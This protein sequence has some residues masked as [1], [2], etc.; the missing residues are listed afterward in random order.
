M[1]RVLLVSLSHS[2]RSAAY[3]LLPFSFIALIAWSTAGSESGST[4]D[5]IRG[6]I[7]IW[8]GAHHIPFQ[9]SLPP[10]AIAGYLTYLPIGGLLLPLLVIRT[11]F[12]RALEKLKGDYHDLNAV[13]LNFSILYSL[14]VT[15][16]AFVSRS[17]PVAAQWYLAPLFAFV[18]ALI[19]T[20]TVGNRVVPSRSLRISL[21]VLSILLGV[22]LI[23]IS[24]LILLN[25]SQVRDI[26]TSLQPGIFGGLLLLFLNIL[27]LPNA[28]VAAASYFSGSG[29][30]VG[31]GSLIS[32]YWY[33]LDQ[34][35]ALPLLGILP[36]GREP[37]ALTGAI[38][39]IGLGVLMAYLTANFDL[40]AIAQSYLFAVIG[41]VVLG[42]LASGSLITAEMGAMGVSIWKFALCVAVEMGIGLALA[43]LIT[44]KV[45]SHD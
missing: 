38:F 26:T 10:T 14:I 41:L 43:I 16:L 11:S 32:P 37:L 21:R 8:L 4:T 9:L 3:L 5:P 45:S 20:M 33:N 2:L 15:A 36:V 39:F 40:L 7:W 22:S 34:I 1:Q 42:Y 19:S 44:K 31:A 23:V 6:A 27:Y 28:A 13:R 35:P 30:A 17:N 12:T 25:F 18:I 29:L 24:L